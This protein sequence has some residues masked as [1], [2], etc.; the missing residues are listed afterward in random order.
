MPLAILCRNSQKRWLRLTTGQ[1]KGYVSCLRHAPQKNDNKTSI[2]NDQEFVKCRMFP[3]EKK[4]SSSRKRPRKMAKCNKSP[5]RPRE[6]V[7]KSCTW[8]TKPKFTPPYFHF[9]LWDCQEH[10]EIFVE[11]FSLNK[12]DQGT[13]CVKFEENPIKT[14][15]NC[16]RKKRR[17]TQPNIF[18]TGGPP[19]YSNSSNMSFPQT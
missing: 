2:T 1:P 3:E 8:R 10:H 15:E 11:D 6:A 12:D 16:L 19:F 5:Y 7:E 4:K 14:Q 13:E 18:A 9:N 17:A